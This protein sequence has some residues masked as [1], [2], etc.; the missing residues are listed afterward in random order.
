MG[1]SSLTPSDFQPEQLD[2]SQAQPQC[3]RRPT[4]HTPSWPAW[5]PPHPITDPPVTSL[6]DTAMPI[7]GTPCPPHR[8]H[9]TGSVISNS[10]PNT[11]VTPPACFP[12]RM[13]LASP[14]VES[15]G[16]CG[17]T[18][19]RAFEGTAAPTPGRP[20]LS[21]LAAQGTN[22][23]GSG[24]PGLQHLTSLSLSVSGRGMKFRPSQVFSEDGRGEV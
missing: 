2:R 9:H 8:V 15:Q 3:P 19:S 14:G 5:A 11:T 6:P 17:E 18:S 1:D 21:A 13:R 20:R 16:S 12:G 7:T 24:V 4:P 10:H 22:L 23:S